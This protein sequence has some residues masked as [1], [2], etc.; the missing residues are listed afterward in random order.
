MQPNQSDAKVP[1]TIRNFCARYSDT[2]GISD[3]ALRW[4]I[5]HAA[6][7]GLA[8]SGAIKRVGARIFIIPERYFRWVESEPIATARRPDGKARRGRPVN[9]DAR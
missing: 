9:A 7:N 3:P 5:S 6:Q 4:Q 1:H 8:E 2:L